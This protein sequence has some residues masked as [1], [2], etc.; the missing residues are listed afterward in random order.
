LWVIGLAVPEL[1]VPPVLLIPLEP[2][3]PELPTEPLVELPMVPLFDPG[4]LPGG[5]TVGEVV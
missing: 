2:I 3:D 5:F 4:V 1:I